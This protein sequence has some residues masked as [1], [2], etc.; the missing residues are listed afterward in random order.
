MRMQRDAML[1]TCVVLIG[2][3]LLAVLAV[4]PSTGDAGAA[5]GRFRATATAGPATAVPPTATPRFRRPAALPVATATDAPVPNPPAE[6]EP[7][8]QTLSD[9]LVA[10]WTMNEAS[11]TRADSVGSN[12]LANVRAYD[13]G[14]V[15]GV[16]GNAALFEW[17]T[18]EATLSAADAPALRFASNAPWTFAFWWKR[19]EQSSAALITKFADS[20][21]TTPEFSL[22]MQPEANRLLVLFGGNTVAC[23]Q[24]IQRDS[25][26][27]LITLRFDGADTLSVSVDAGT[28]RAWTLASVAAPGSGAFQLNPLVLGSASLDEM[29]KWDRALTDDEVAALYNSG[30]GWSP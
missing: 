6:P 29:G 8:L 17:Y 2:L 19:G 9:G 23:I 20:G 27:H 1:R 30:A 16:V 4:W 7:E 5:H 13:A 26:W 12:D 15:P 21:N 14:G 18:N 10:Y 11:G 28:P 25:N 24:C 3:I 22:L